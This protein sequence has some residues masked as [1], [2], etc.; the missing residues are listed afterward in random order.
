LVAYLQEQIKPASI[1][2]ASLLEKRTAKSCGFKGDYVG[3][4]VPDEFVVGYCLDYNEVYR[5]LT[6][7]CIINQE[8][9]DRFKDYEHI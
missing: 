6:H 3:F 2:V 1:R 8:G 4:S 9:I 7:I 5:D